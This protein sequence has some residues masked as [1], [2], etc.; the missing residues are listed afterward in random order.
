MLQA[1]NAGDKRAQVQ[2]A[3]RYENGL[4]V[5]QDHELAEDMM[6]KLEHEDGYAMKAYE[7]AM[8]DV[9][10]PIEIPGKYVPM[11][12]QGQLGVLVIGF[13]YSAGHAVNP[14][15]VHTCNVKEIDASV[16]DKLQHLF[17]PPPPRDMPNMNPLKIGIDLANHNLPN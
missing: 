15:V 5:A 8:S 12:M 3:V 7:E 4:G 10:Y 2:V 16:I 14:T 13:Q 17:L 11:M 1:A 9:L 6:D